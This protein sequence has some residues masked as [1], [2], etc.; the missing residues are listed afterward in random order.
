MTQGWSRRPD[1]TATTQRLSKKTQYT[2]LGR[3]TLVGWLLS[4]SV[5]WACSGNYTPIVEI[6]GD[7]EHSPL[8]GKIV[9]TRGIVTANVPNEGVFIQAPNADPKR[10]SGL[11]LF[12]KNTSLVV[13]ADVRVTGQVKEYY[14]LTELTNV[15][16]EERCGIATLPA[17]AELSSGEN[18]AN[19]EALEGMRV[20]VPA[21]TVVR[22]DGLY[23]F[24][25]LSVKLNGQNSQLKLDDGYSRAPVSV[26]HYLASAKG[27]KL[28]QQAKPF[29]G[30][31]YYAFDHYRLVPE[32][33]LNLTA[34]EDPTV[35]PKAETSLRV[36]SINLE[37]F[38]NGDGL[39][40]GFPAPRGPKSAREYE[41]KRQK[42]A[43]ALTQLQADLIAVQ[44]I[45]NDGVDQ[46]P[47]LTDLANAM[48]DIDGAGTWAAIAPLGQQAGS[49]SLTQGFLVRQSRLRSEGELRSSVVSRAVTT[50]RPVL[51][52]RFR[53]QQS[54]RIF[55]TAVVHLKSKGGRCASDTPRLTERWGACALQRENAVRTLS[56]WVKQKRPDN[57]PILLLGD[58]N[59][60]ANEPAMRALAQLGWHL[61]EGAE[62]RS[63][64]WFNGQPQRLD[65][66]LW[67]QNTAWLN[68]E[69]WFWPVNA[70]V[71][72][73]PAEAGKAWQ[74]LL[75]PSWMGF[76]DH[77]PLVL[78]LY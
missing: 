68:T 58:I 63:G 7:S 44:E 11:Y 21:S 8:N 46:R 71:L 56:S 67:M 78:D 39:G 3:L 57:E 74:A 55:S 51:L 16:V 20:Q 40:R 65:W 25:E 38:F 33:P 60:V 12:V 61:P 13:G 52:Q 2:V 18:A 19:W 62:Q 54:N 73:V 48:N 4:L 27:L 49:D 75:G 64:Y 24:G 28:G 15:R 6:Q 69:E 30:V 26:P 50:V 72:K 77:D 76:S 36:V 22:H 9:T 43:T 32:S 5:A 17:P 35:K 37:N 45:E 70:G 31:M 14:G 59:S 53:D 42:T 29:V 41:M 10:S 47:A 34:F 1:F 66:V 23:R